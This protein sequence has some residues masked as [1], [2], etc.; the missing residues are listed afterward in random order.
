MLSSSYNNDTFPGMQ[1]HMSSRSSGSYY[2]KTKNTALRVWW[3][4]QKRGQTPLTEERL[5]QKWKEGSVCWSCFPFRCFA[6]SLLKSLSVCSS[7]GLGCQTPSDCTTF[8]HEELIL[9][10]IPL[11]LK[12]NMEHKLDT[13]HICSVCESVCVCVPH[14]HQRKEQ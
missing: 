14:T 2:N 8:W 9:R 4:N 7:A 13:Q 1:S 12:Q 10:L 6:S 5:K 11:W 3:R